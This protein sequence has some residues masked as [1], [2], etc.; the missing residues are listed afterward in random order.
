MGFDFNGH[1][2]KT[3][4]GSVGVGSLAHF[5]QVIIDADKGQG[6]MV[7][8]GPSSLELYGAD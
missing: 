7:L 6:G 5:R 2:I 1:R 8:R 4:T 3:D